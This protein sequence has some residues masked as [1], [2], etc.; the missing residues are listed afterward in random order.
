MVSCSVPINASMRSIEDE[1]VHLWIIPLTGDST[2]VDACFGVLNHEERSRAKRLRFTQDQ[3]RFVLARGSLRLILAEYLSTSPEAVRFHYGPNGKPELENDGLDLSLNF[4]LSHSHEVG[5]L[6][7]TRGRRIGVDIEKVAS[8]SLDEVDMG[9]HLFTAAE[10]ELIRSASAEERTTVFYRLWTRKEAY[11]KGRGDG[12]SGALNGF[13]V[14]LNGT[15][16]RLLPVGSA[17]TENWSVHEFRPCS[18]YIA[19]LA[20]EGSLSKL[21]YLNMRV[22]F[23]AELGRNFTIYQAREA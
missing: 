4:N 20:I 10:A 5:C 7:L 2:R 8:R 3:E 13:E 11:L 14:S 12:L 21:K 16:I 9:E 19:A 18:G 23:G 17:G 22:E 15:S 6:A 1:E